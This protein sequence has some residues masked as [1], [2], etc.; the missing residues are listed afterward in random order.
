MQVIVAYLGC[1]CVV[2][3]AAREYLPS[4]PPAGNCPRCGKPFSDVRATEVR[5]VEGVS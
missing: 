3:Y 5:I 1:G 2:W 4:L